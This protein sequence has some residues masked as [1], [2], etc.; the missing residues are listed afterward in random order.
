MVIATNQYFDERMRAFCSAAGFDDPAFTVLPAIMIPALLEKAQIPVAEVDIASRIGLGKGTLNKA[1]QNVGDAYWVGEIVG[2]LDIATQ[3]EIIK[4]AQSF[5]LE[6]KK[7]EKILEEQ[8]EAKRPQ[9]EIREKKW[10]RFLMAVAP[11]NPTPEQTF[12]FVCE[13]IAYKTYKDIEDETGILKS[14][15]ANWANGSDPV[16]LQR[17]GI[18]A[19]NLTISNEEAERFILLMRPDIIDPPEAE[20]EIRKW[21]REKIEA[22]NWQDI[23]L[24]SLSSNEAIREIKWKKFLAEAA[25]NTPTPEQTLRF[26]REKVALKAPVD[27]ENETGISNATIS[28]WE[29]RRYPVS[30]TEI[31]KLA[32]NLTI[33]DTEAERFIVLM[34]PDIISPPAKETLLREWLREKI[35]TKSWH[36]ISFPACSSDEIWLL[37]QQEHRQPRLLLDELIV[38]N[39]THTMELGKKIGDSRGISNYVRGLSTPN[40]LIIGNLACA[41]EKTSAQNVFKLITRMRP[42][43]LLQNPD[44]QNVVEKW[45]LE[46]IEAKDRKALGLPALCTDKIWLHAQPVRNWPGLILRDMIAEQAEFNKAISQGSVSNSLGIDK[47]LMSEWIHGKKLITMEKA[48]AIANLPIFAERKDEFLEAVI[49]SRASPRI[50]VKDSNASLGA[51]TKAT[52]QN[53][54]LSPGN[55]EE[56]RR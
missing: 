48:E 28:N 33:S 18:L 46:K 16:N 26:A 3:I 20:T 29:L 36:D 44:E 39:H 2:A 34:R 31:G 53:T 12:K 56:I 27:L 11:N 35:E 14:T 51:T 8:Q 30:P 45:L 13:V 50:L 41:L 4:A 43:L 47:R 24:S 55:E 32:E 42:E 25:P 37:A 9:I 23:S 1:T 54:L 22:K 52:Y 40:L 19:E 49:L 5:A 17:I 38:E 21:L 15:I 7:A 10:K 6:K